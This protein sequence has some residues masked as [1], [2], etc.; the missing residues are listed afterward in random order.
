MNDSTTME[1]T[2]RD[3]RVASQR[4]FEAKNEDDVWGVI[5][6]LWRLTNSGQLTVDMIRETKIGHTLG[7]YCKRTCGKCNSPDC[8]FCDLIAAWKQMVWEITT[9]KNLN[10]IEETK[11]SEEV[12]KKSPSNGSLRSSLKLPSI[13]EFREHSNST[14]DSNSELD[15]D[16]IQPYHP[17]Q[18]KADSRLKSPQPL[19]RA[20]DNRGDIRSRNSQR[21]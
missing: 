8:D 3:L 21:P 9:K 7:S 17:S 18:G 5:E 16:I 13:P 12:I 14:E 20:F 19:Q 15:N 10:K 2:L 11:E 6:I 4:L 1:Q